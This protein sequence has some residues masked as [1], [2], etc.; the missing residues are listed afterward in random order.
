M[1]QPRLWLELITT[2]APPKIL[3]GSLGAAPLL[4]KIRVS[5]SYFFGSTVSFIPLPTRNFRVVLAG[6]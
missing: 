2:K 5:D 6:I 1:L 4:D 3:D